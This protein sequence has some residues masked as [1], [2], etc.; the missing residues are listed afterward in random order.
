MWTWCSQGSGSC[1][2]MRDWCCCSGTDRV[3][4]TPQ[5]P[6]AWMSIGRKLTGTE[7]AGLQVSVI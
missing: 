2:R 3:S 6:R 7:S 5:M 1:S 4:V